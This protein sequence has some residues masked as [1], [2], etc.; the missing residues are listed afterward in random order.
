MSDDWRKRVLKQFAPGASRLTV[1]ADP[2]GILLEEGIA[3]EIR[4]RGIELLPY[5]DPVR[6]W[7]AFETGY[8]SRWDQG[9]AGELVV[10]L[11]SEERDLNGLPYDI[12]QAA[13]KVD[14]SLMDHFPGLSYPVLRSLDMSC[15]D[16]L[17]DALQKFPQSDLGEKDTCR[18]VMHHVFQMAPET[19]LT[20][21]GLLN[22]LLRKH[23]QRLFIPLP[24]DE[25]F[26]EV[27]RL[28]GG[29]NDWPVERLIPDRDTFFAFLQE[30][31]PVYLKSLDIPESE[32]IK[33]PA[34][35]YG[36]AF[37]GPALL[38]F[39]HDDIRI[40][41][42]NLFLE[43]RLKPVRLSDA[44]R[45]MQQWVAVGIVIDEARRKQERVK[46]LMVSAAS[47]LPDA[48][49]FYHAWISYAFK[50]ASLETALAACS[51]DSFARLSK[52]FQAIQRSMDQRFLEWLCNRYGGLYNQPPNP[53]VMVHHIPGFLANYM[54]QAPEKKVA[55]I[56]IDGLS[57][58]QWMT[59]KVVLQDQINDIQIHEDGVFAWIPTI[60]SLSRQAAFSGKL[61]I[62]FKN[63]IRT[64]DREAALWEQF[65]TDHGLRAKQI[66]FLKSLGN[67]ASVE[68]IEALADRPQL[69]VAGL[70]INTVDDIMHGMQLGTAGMYA[71]VRQWGETGF[72]KRVFQML[73]SRGFAV[74]IS[75]D[76][77]NVEAS[78]I[79]MPK[80]GA[81]VDTRGERVRV[82]SDD[83][84]RSQVA[85]KFPES[86]SWPRLGLPE[87]YFPLFAPDRKAFIPEGKQTVAHGGPAIEEVIVPFVRIHM[88]G[89]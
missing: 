26:I 3:A 2:D 49:A 69:R 44:D 60:T 65:W 13:R 72:L 32:R 16:A 73:D 67:T 50:W 18:F 5:D 89:C 45:L 33:M 20:D 51:S 88:R 30:R 76:H 46:R 7:Y 11:R 82:Y 42:D 25:W 31:W 40:Y 80:E 84:L 38:P 39:G 63:S 27:L 66:G 35:S 37:Q 64:T 12:L 41:M 9:E 58:G 1:A 24:L 77:G 68:K 53:P 48:H 62:Y 83:V 56:L 52:E 19:I 78:G 54:G 10:V 57:L 17:D 85:D 70:V 29:F 4:R 22:V 6:F 79:G 61:P 87:D 34:S 43:G 59:L 74:F 8:R 86:I 75:S 14:L 47:S 15:Y 81:L 23:Y 28:N 21:S 71:Q 55:F 36:L